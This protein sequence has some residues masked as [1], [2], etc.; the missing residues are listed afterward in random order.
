MDSILEVRDAS[1]MEAVDALMIA[2]AEFATR[3]KQVTSEHW[4]LPTPCTEWNVRAL[5]NHVLLGT[6]MSVQILSGM[7]RD[8]V[9]S[10][11]NDDLIGGT[12]DPVASFVELATQMVEGFSGPGGLDGMVE[13][14]AGDFPRSV[15]CGFRIADGALHA[16]DLARAI[17]VDETLDPDIIQLLWDGAQPQRE[18]LVATGLFGDGASGNVGEDAPLQTRYLD[19][20]GRRP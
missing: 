6:R 16:W 18:T 19:L 8:E 20:M 1:E 3:L 11:L 14:P 10:Y 9:I 12:D 15:F 13:H 5:V 7:P 2:N 4:D 17:G